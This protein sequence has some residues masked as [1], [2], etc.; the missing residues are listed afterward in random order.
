MRKVHGR[1]ERYEELELDEPAVEQHVPVVSSTRDLAA[2]ALYD[3]CE[4]LL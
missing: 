1:D 2:L 4:V 3:L